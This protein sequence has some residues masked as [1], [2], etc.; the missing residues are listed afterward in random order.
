MS[1][2]YLL[3]T[4]SNCPACVEAKNILKRNGV[5]FKECDVENGG[6]DIARR[7]SIY[8]V[9]SLLVLKNGSPDELIVGVQSRLK[10]LS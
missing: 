5:K 9:P 3:F 7:Y 6:A 8:S 10:E 2:E 4:S 1:T